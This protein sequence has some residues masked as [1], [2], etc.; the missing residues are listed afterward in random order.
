[1]TATCR[2]KPTGICVGLGAGAVLAQGSLSARN[3]LAGGWA[4]GRSPGGKC[5]PLPVRTNAVSSA[6][7][8][9]TSADNGSQLRDGASAETVEFMFQ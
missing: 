9:R 7:A 1:M 3:G 6:H 8:S 4:A 5:S 2:R